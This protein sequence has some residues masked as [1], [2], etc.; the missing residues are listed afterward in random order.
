MVSLILLLTILVKCFQTT[1]RT[2]PMRNYGILFAHTSIDSDFYCSFAFAFPSFGV[3]FDLGFTV[4]LTALHAYI[5]QDSM[6][7]DFTNTNGIC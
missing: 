2:I 3:L 4:L 5:F 6:R 7:F 1:R